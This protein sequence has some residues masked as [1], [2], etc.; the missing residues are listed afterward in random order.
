MYFTYPIDKIDVDREKDWDKEQ[1]KEKKEGKKVCPNWKPAVNS[2]RAL[3]DKD[4]ATLHRIKEI[5]K[6]GGSHLI[7]LLEQIKF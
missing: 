6:D 3:L 4:D 2:L 1:R 7:E 5:D